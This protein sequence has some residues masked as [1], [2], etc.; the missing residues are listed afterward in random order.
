MRFVASLIFLLLSCIPTQASEKPTLTLYYA[1]WCYACHRVVNYL[2]QINKQAPLKDVQYPENK[3][4]LIT[5][6]GKKQVPC[7]FIDGEPLYESEAIIDWLSTHLD[8][9]EDIEEQ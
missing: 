1:P 6:G 5:Y 7:L 8:F 2:K 9:L 4:T 3:D